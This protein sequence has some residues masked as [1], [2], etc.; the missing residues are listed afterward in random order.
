MRENN[1]KIFHHLTYG[2]V[3]WKVSSYGQK[4]FFIWGPVGGLETIPSEYS[5]YYD[6]KSKL[7]EFLRRIVDKLMPLNISFQTRS[8]RADLI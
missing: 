4:Q 2:N 8:R 3:L 1:I 6:R 5:A 7:I